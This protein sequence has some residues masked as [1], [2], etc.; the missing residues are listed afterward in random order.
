MGALFKSGSIRST[1]PPYR[2]NEAF[3]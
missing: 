1:Q 2:Q 3:L